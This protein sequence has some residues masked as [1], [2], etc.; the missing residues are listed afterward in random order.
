VRFDLERVEGKSSDL[1]K[2]LRASRA[3]PSISSTRQ[4]YKAATTGEEEPE[5]EA[6]ALPADA[7]Q[8]HGW[9]PRQPKKERAPM[10][11]TMQGAILIQAMFSLDAP[12]VETII[13]R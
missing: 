2:V 5:A 9:K 1:A 7:A 4:S 12:A 13:N 10:E 8:R 11:P 3:D 6:E